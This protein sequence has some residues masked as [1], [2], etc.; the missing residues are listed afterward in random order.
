MVLL[1]NL[2]SRY[3]Y[4]YATAMRIK[5]QKLMEFPFGQFDLINVVTPQFIGDWWW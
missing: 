3:E 2:M 4:D 5:R 1:F